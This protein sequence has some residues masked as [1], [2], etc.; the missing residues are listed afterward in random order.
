MYKYKLLAGLS[1][2]IAILIL[3]YIIYSYESI[4]MK[5]SKEGEIITFETNV[6]GI[7]KGKKI[8]WGM[9]NKGAIYLNLKDETKYSIY[10]I[11]QNNLYSDENLIDFL[12]PNDSISKK[13]NSDTLYIYRDNQEYYFVLG[14]NIN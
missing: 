11:S 2:I 9:R 13:A 7:I 3:V 5:Y 6:T 10:A 12:Q 8:N 14:K 4:D 1:A